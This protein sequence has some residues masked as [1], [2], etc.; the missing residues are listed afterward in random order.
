MVEAVIDSARQQAEIEA[1]FAERSRR[2]QEGSL[3]VK[4]C[5]W[6]YR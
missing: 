4:C 6:K 1:L 3:P 2:V 5:I